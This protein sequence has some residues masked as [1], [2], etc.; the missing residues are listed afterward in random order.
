[1]E[2]EINS[3]KISDSRRSID[4]NTVEMLVESFKDV[5]VLHPI[6]IDY[7]YNLIAGAHRVEA[8]KRLGWNT[9]SCTMIDFSEDAAKIAEEDESDVRTPNI[10]TRA[11]WLLK[12]KER[13]E[14]LYPETKAHI[15]GGIARQNLASEEKFACSNMNEEQCRNEEKFAKQKTFVQQEAEKRGVSERAIEQEIQI[16]QNIEPDIMDFVEDININKTNALNLARKTPVEQHEIIE[17]IR[18]AVQAVPP[19]DASKRLITCLTKNLRRIN[20]RKKS[21]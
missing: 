7:D 3:I 6:V 20:R 14:A 16:A 9:I 5:G 13:Y 11:K 19:A 21:K 1:M 15:A 17:P 12:R 4:E 2:I 18:E 8:A 10:V